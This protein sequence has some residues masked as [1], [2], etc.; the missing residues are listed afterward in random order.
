[1]LL[2]SERRVGEVLVLLAGVLVVVVCSSAGGPRLVEGPGV[3]CLSFLR[4]VGE[5]VGHARYAIRQ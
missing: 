2:S 3:G 4:R 5:P 1:M